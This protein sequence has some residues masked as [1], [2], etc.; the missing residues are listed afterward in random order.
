MGQ[1]QAHHEMGV[2]LLG[3]SRDES[4]DP[5]FDLGNVVGFLQTLRVSIPGFGELPPEQMDHVQGKMG[6]R[7]PVCA[8]GWVAGP[9]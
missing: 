8:G 5:L 7:I 3:L 4:F 2:S 6:P 1:E 9:G